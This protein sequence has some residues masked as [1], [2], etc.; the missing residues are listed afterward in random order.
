M[1]NEQVFLIDVDNTLLDNGAI[2]ADLKEEIGARLGL[3]RERRYWEIFQQRWDEVGFADYLGALERLRAADPR[4]QEI[5][6]VSQFLLNYKF[7]DRVYS[8]AV[9]VIH[10]LRR[11]AR[12]VVV[13]DGDVVYQPHKID[14]AGL[15]AAVDGDVL[16]YIHK[17]AMLED[18]E[19]RYPAQHYVMVDDKLRILTAIKEIWRERVTTVFVRQG[20]YAFD[21]AI[22]AAF[23]PADLSI[24]RIADLTQAV[25]TF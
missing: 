5:A 25:A 11:R 12:V 17:E 7:A 13:S 4:D 14:R 10:E 15:R 9:E 20:M 2:V 6:L 16:V 22:L 19:R 18:V 23:P 3:A 1:D 21:P 8:G 24:D